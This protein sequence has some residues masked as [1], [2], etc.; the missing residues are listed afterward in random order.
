MIRAVNNEFVGMSMGRKESNV[1][2]NA[3]PR[4]V[5]WKSPDSRL[6]PGRTA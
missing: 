5:C 1:R 3:V 6:K 2:E 4:T